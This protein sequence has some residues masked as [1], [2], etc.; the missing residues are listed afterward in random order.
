MVL[1]VM[2]ARRSM[3]FSFTDHCFS[4]PNFFRADSRVS[5]V[6]SVA[7]SVASW[8]TVKA[9]VSSRV[10]FLGMKTSGVGRMSSAK[11]KWVRSP[12]WARVSMR[13]WTSAAIWVR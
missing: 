9:R 12:N 2:M 13:V 10:R 6:Q 7:S 8:S 1:P 11:K 3:K 5:M 4:S